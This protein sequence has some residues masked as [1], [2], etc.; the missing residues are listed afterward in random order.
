MHFGCRQP[1]QNKKNKQHFDHG[2]GSSYRSS[3]LNAPE[4]PCS[5]LMKTMSASLRG[6]FLVWTTATEPS[7]LSSI[8]S[9]FIIS[10]AWNLMVDL[11][12]LHPNAEPKHF[13]WMLLHCKT[14]C[15]NNAGAAFCHCNKDTFAFWT[16]QMV[17]SASMLPTV[18]HRSCC[19]CCLLEL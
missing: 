18:S 15:S 10:V 7:E 4:A 14:Y 1:H 3:L 17:V 5:T 12:L 8:F 13:L 16:K 6:I 19:C 11:A 9:P 2:N